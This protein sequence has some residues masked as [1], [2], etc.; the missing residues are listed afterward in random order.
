MKYIFSIFVDFDFNVIIGKMLISFY[1]ATVFCDLCKLHS[2]F[3][4]LI[5]L[6]SNALDCV[7]ITNSYIAGIGFVVDYLKQIHYLKYYGV[8]TAGRIGIHYY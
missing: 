8:M 2:I 6:F 4:F 1:V 7:N 3:R 5:S